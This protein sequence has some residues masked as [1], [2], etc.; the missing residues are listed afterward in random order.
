MAGVPTAQRTYKNIQEE[1]E[2]RGTGKR[3]ARNGSEGI[4]SCP[5]VWLEM[6][7]EAGKQEFRS[8]AEGWGLRREWYV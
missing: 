7:T 2:L 5:S 3:N 1:E 6:W 4:N 8:L